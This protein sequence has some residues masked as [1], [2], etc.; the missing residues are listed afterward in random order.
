MLKKKITDPRKR[1]HQ[2]IRKKIVGTSERP[3]LVVFRSLKH[4][5]AQVID[6]SANKVLAHAS[7]LPVKG[8]EQL[9]GDKSNRAK[10]VGSRVA[11]ICKDK[12]IERV[13]FD[14]AGYLYHGRVSKVAE[15]AREGGLEF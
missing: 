6:D 3:R 14:R 12:G 4:I 8:A 11:Q 1:R 9:E 15:G 2:S 7:D 13:V 5:Y 10:K